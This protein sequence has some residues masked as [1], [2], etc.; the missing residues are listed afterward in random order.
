MGNLLSSKTSKC[1]RQPSG[2]RQFL[3]AYKQ[4]HP[5]MPQKQMTLSALR[6][7]G[8]LSPSQKMSFVNVASHTLQKLNITD[9]SRARARA[10]RRRNKKTGTKTQASSLPECDFNS[11]DD[12][13]F[14][15]FMNQYRSVHKELS[16]S[17]LC[18][19]GTNAWTALTEEQKNLFKD[20]PR[21]VVLLEHCTCSSIAKPKARA[22]RKKK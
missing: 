3:R 13:R 1:K 8:K 11:D 2:Y 14:P 10:R 9:R 21:T 20:T 17:E 19:Q 5:D 15:I 16:E 7:W 12:I 22:R 4:K 18:Q 6:N